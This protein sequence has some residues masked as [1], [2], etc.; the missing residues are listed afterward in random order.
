MLTDYGI[1]APVDREPR[2]W[3]YHAVSIGFSLWG[4]ERQTQQHGEQKVD[5]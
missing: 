1:P 2:G 3:P 5:A 4:P